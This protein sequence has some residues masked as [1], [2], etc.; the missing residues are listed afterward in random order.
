M[1]ILI[2]LSSLCFCMVVILYQTE[3]S[4]YKSLPNLL[5]RDPHLNYINLHYDVLGSRLKCMGN[6]EIHYNLLDRPQS[7][8]TLKI[9]H[10]MYGLRLKRIGNLEIQYYLVN[11]AARIGDLEIRYD[12]WGTRLKRIGD[13]EIQYGLLGNIRT[14]G[15][16]ELQYKPWSIRPTYIVTQQRHEDSVQ[17]TLILL[18]VVYELTRQLRKQIY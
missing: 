16:L 15:D 12:R 7:I 14:L 11:Q 2:T 1:D 8:G 13:L 4:R 6:L 9:E 3:A 5:D 10:D 17:Q 18:F